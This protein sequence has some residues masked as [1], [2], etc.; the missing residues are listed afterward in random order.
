MLILSCSRKVNNIAYKCEKII[1]VHPVKTEQ[2]DQVH[3]VKTLYCPVLMLLISL[4]ADCMC[5]LQDSNHY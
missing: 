4:V 3:P 2:T 5:T 1:L